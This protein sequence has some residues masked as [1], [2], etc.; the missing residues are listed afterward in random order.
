MQATKSQPTIADSIRQMTP[1]SAPVEQQ[2]SLVALARLLTMV[3]H[4][5]AKRA[6]ECQLV[7]PDG[8]TLP[9]PAPVFQLLSHVVDVLARGDAITI[10]P[11]GKELTTQQAANVLNLSRQYL[12]RLL[13]E[14]RIPYT[15]T[16]KHR[17][18]RV[19]DVIAFKQMRDR[20][21]RAK[22]DDL[23]QLSEDAGGYDEIDATPTSR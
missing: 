1:I 21:R 14:G 5:Q 12:V 8:N 18:L 4:H 15:R 19:E 6:S 17:R 2:K 16:G 7:G 9:L 13:D 20:E 11:V 10:V 22:L 23:A 3:H